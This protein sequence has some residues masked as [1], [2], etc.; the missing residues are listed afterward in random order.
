L[1]AYAGERENFRLICQKFNSFWGGGFMRPPELFFYERDKSFSLY[2]VQT[3]ELY[4]DKKQGEHQ[5]AL[6]AFEVL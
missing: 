5:G 1:F 2:R 4:D 6:G 3:R